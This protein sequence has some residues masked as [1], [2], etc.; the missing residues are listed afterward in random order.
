MKDKTHKKP[1][2]V[3]GF[4]QLAGQPED[5]GLTIALCAVVE[6]FLSSQEFN[7]IFLRLSTIEAA[8]QVA[9]E[10]PGNF[11]LFSNCPSNAAYENKP[12]KTNKTTA[13]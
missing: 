6:K 1:Q 10:N 13:A 11:I 8:S 12:L 3:V 7:S 4:L 9:A 5:E 2:F